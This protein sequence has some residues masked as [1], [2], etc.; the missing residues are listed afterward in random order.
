[1]GYTATSQTIL[2]FWRLVHRMENRF[3]RLLLA[4]VTGSDR[5]PVGGLG[6][7]RWVIQRS[8]LTSALP[9][10]STCYNTLHLPDYPS[11]DILTAKLQLAVEN[12]R[13]FGLA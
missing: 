13:G 3:K 5:A 8:E 6:S 1:M 9:S 10:S 12:C 4:F 11:E 2:R 7:L